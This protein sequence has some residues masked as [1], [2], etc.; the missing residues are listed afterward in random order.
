MINI[1]GRARPMGIGRAESRIEADLAALDPTGGDLHAAHG[2]G[3]IE[4]VSPAPAD[5]VQVEGDSRAHATD[6]VNRM[7]RAS[8]VDTDAGE[9]ARLVMDADEDVRWWAAQN[10]STPTLAL[11]ACLEEEVHHL[12]ITALLNNPQLPSDN[13]ERFAKH[14][15]PDV[16]RAASRRLKEMVSESP[17][18]G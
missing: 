13:I 6:G 18:S 1:Y 7:R 3:T 11:V 10:P 2:S 9:L 16:K 4:V 12:V 8:D 14:P 5:I 15:S 17:Q